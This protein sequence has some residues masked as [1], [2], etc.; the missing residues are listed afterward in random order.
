[1]FGDMFGLFS[2]SMR[3]CPYCIV[4]DE[5]TYLCHVDASNTV[6][7]DKD[8]STLKEAYA[9]VRCKKQMPSTEYLEVDDLIHILLLGMDREAL[10]RAATLIIEHKKF[11]LEKA[12]EEA[13]E[14]R[15]KRA[16]EKSNENS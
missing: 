11:V 1:M 10:K 14:A 15:Q 9:C 7:P 3:L 8:I 5:T 6:F 2:T 16:K 12:K 4:S 13:E